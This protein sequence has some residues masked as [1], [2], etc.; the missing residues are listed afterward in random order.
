MEKLDQGPDSALV[1]STVPPS[2]TGMSTIHE[3][4]FVALITSAQL[5]TQAGFAQVIAPLHIQGSSFGNPNNGQLSWFAAAYSL[6]A[7]TFILIAGRLGDMFGHRKIFITGYFWYCLWSVIAGVAVY[8]KSQEFFDFCRAMQGIGPALLLPNALAIFGLTYPPG[9]KKNL[10]FALFGA[11]APGGFVVG[12]A[13]SGLLAER[14]WWPWAYWIM[15]IVCCL[16]AVLGIFLIPKY[17]EDTSDDPD[18]MSFD[19]LGAI[20]GVTG[21][22]LFN[23]AWNQ[24]P[25]AGWG[26]AYVP[27]LL[28]L[29]LLFLVAFF[30]VE[31]RAKKPLLPLEGLSGDAAFVLGCIALGWSSFGIW[32]FYV[33]QFLEEL[34][35]I[36]PLLAAAQ[37]S[38]AAI[39]GLVAAITTGLALTH[40]KTA[41]VMIIA[42][43][44]FCVGVILVAT[45]PIRQTYWAQLFV[46]TLVTC[47]GMDMSF[48]AATI[49]LSNLVPSRNQG[50]AASLV[51]TVV[52]YSISIGLGIAGTVEVHVNRGGN[53][54]ADVLRGYRGAL[55]AG[56]GTSGLGIVLA[57]VFALDGLRKGKLTKVEG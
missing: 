46:A 9:L 35:H 40:L 7:G 12:A 18:R 19:W 43:T 37:I 41:Y 22:V 26:D 20:T 3:I 39:S 10:I 52:N 11:T 34:R 21:L 4:A 49:L 31:K 33:W 50:I 14:A 57:I 2:K 51:I 15:A 48:P 55:Y 30:F 53:N 24:G 29:G 28:V 23:V 16:C 38:P 47:W 44:A 42:M 6:T 27:V 36:S 1:D 54:V 5:L 8:S 13:F 56:I 25:V 45:M 32:V 17:P